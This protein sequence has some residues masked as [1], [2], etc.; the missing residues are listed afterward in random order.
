VATNPDSVVALHRRVVEHNESH[1]GS[2]RRI[3]RVALLAE[4]PAID[5]GETTD[6][7]YVNQQAVVEHSADVVER[8]YRGDPLP[9]IV[10]IV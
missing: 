10:I 8:L 9:D 1:A 5:R 2:S 4:P 7:G 6:R 3:C